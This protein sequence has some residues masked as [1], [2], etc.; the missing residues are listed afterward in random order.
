MENGQRILQK[1]VLIRAKCRQLQ[2]RLRPLTPWAGAM[3]GQMGNG[4]RTL[5]KCI[6]ISSV[7]IVKRWGGGLTKEFYQLGSTPNPPSIRTLLISIKCRQLQGDE[8]PLIPWPGASPLDP[9]WSKPPNPIRGS[10]VLSRFPTCIK[11]HCIILFL[12]Q[13]NTYTKWTPLRSPAG[14]NQE[15]V[16]DDFGVLIVWVTPLFS[17]VSVGHGRNLVLKW[18]KIMK[19][20][21]LI[22]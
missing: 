8:V 17:L 4:Q 6:L 21:R 1:F 18:N 15:N 2:G 9:T 16:F 19:I 7:R 5:H 11:C 14:G 12:T 10:I 13:I 20:Y 3:L 22:I